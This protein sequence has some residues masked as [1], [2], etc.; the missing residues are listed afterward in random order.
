MT[1]HVSS[2]AAFLGRAVL[3]LCGSDHIGERAAAAAM[4]ANMVR[5]SGLTWAPLLAEPPKQEPIEDLIAF[6]AAH[7]NSLTDWEWRF[8]RDIRGFQHL[9][10]KQRAT[11]ERIVAKVR[12]GRAAA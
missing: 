7:G 8:L 10:D 12:S 1:T 6:A 9:S 11:L 2:S 5:K 3:G 4:A